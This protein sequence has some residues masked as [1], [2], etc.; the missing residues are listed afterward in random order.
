MKIDERIQALL[1]YLDEQGYETY[2]V[3]GAVRDALLN[4]PIHDYDILTKAPFAVVQSFFPNDCWVSFKRAIP[5]VW[6]VL[7]YRW[8]FVFWK[9]I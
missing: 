9:R 6:L 5:F 2:L 1:I 7:P 3:G 4:R 8:M